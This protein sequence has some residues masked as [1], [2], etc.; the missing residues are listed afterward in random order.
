MPLSA[1]AEKTTSSFILLPFPFAVAVVVSVSTLFVV[2]S[3]F[4]YGEID[5]SDGWLLRRVCGQCRNV[6]VSY[7]C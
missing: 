7:A 2:A 3:V 6:A 5:L 1:L 4:G